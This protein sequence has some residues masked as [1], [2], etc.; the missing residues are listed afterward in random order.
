MPF[1]LP[2]RWVWDSWF[3]D[4]GERFHLFYL[5][6]PRA[7]V[8]PQLR[9]RNAVIGHATSTDLR[10]WQDHGVVLR[11]GRPGDFDATATWTGCVVPTADGWR[12]FYTGSVFL[13]PQEHTNIETIGAADSPDLEGWTKDAMPPLRADPRWYETL[14][15]WS[16]PEEAWRD[17]WVFFE[18]GRWHMLI[19]ARARIVGEAEDPR[20]RGVVGH[21]TSADLS[22]W[23]VQP[24]LSAPGSGFAHLEV[25]Q[26]FRFGG[27]Q[28]VLFSCDRAHL[29]G[30]RRDDRVGGV[31]VA[32]RD[33]AT[34]RYAVEDARLLHDESLYAARL[35]RGRD[36]SSLLIGFEN[37][38]DDGGFGGRISDPI[39]LTGDDEGWPIV[40]TDA[41]AKR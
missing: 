32:P 21:A 18:D 31:W 8:D 22:S 12:M 10:S 38:G 11:P 33:P 19:T 4:D 25:L 34:G 39:P 30:A 24:P 13:D 36:G 6:A 14:A 26:P 27:R 2:D 23:A 5:N 7:L 37:T 9:H 20:D 35:V 28:F 1:E 15:D 41:E 17:P 29:A 16:W 3:A 40:L